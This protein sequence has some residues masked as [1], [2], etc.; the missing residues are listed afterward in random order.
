MAEKPDEHHDRS[1]MDQN[2]D[3]TKQRKP[4]GVLSGNKYFLLQTGVTFNSHVNF[5]AQLKQKIPSLQKVNKVEECDFVLVFCPVVSRAGTDIE[6]AEK[7]LDA[8]SATKPA[9]LVVFHHTFDP[10]SVV[11]DSCRA[12]TRANTVTVDCLFHEDQGLLHCYKNTKA[13]N[14]IQMQIKPK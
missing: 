12:V 2:K 1:Q 11:P 9:V 6:S 8:T 10:E 4:A 7:K 13:I 14:H 5:I 3:A